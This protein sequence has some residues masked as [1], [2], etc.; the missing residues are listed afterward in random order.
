MTSQIIQEHYN[1]VSHLNN[2]MQK[3]RAMQQKAIMEKL[4]F[5]RNELEE[6]IETQLERD[7]Q[8]EY[9]DRQKR[10]AGYA[11]LALM[12]T[13]LEQ[14]HAKAMLDLESD[15]LAE[16]EKAKSD[17]NMQLEQDLSQELESKSQDFLQQLAAVSKLSK[18]ELS[19]AVSSA[20]SGRPDS[21]ATRKLARDLHDG[22]GRARSSL[23]MD[24]AERD[25]NQQGYERPYSGR[26]AGEVSYQRPGSVRKL[27]AR[28]SRQF[29]QYADEDGF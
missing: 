8:A 23:S 28:Q 12:Q 21:K 4:Q 25:Q 17:L 1:H 18:D 15:M 29:E 13:F 9:T 3:R 2:Q 26:T 19:E 20:T 27:S 16:L 7:A 22:V 6:Q 14:K 5:K 10:G 11:S 24:Y